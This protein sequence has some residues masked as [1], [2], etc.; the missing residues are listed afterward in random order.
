[1]TSATSTEAQTR[2]GE[3]MDRAQREPVSITKNGRKFA[4]LLSQED[5]ER[6][7]AA[8]DRR[9]GLLAQEAKRGGMLTPEETSA[10]LSETQE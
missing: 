8:E 2:F 5:Y 4:V 6:L 9:W 10:F 1:M 7:Q 3:F